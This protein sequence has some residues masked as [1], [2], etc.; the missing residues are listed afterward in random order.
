MG[1]LYPYDVYFVEHIYVS[2][3]N[4]PAELFPLPE[5]G[6]QSQRPEEATM[7]GFPS[8]AWEFS[9]FEIERD[10][11]DNNGKSWFSLLSKVFFCSCLFGPWTRRCCFEHDD[12][13]QLIQLILSRFIH[14]LHLFS[15]CFADI[16]PSKLWIIAY[17]N[18]PTHE[19]MIHPLNQHRPWNNLK[20]VHFVFQLPGNG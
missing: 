7:S 14:Q 4:D 8:A 6:M 9:F 1:L 16:F 5:P 2:N 13:T 3:P 15:Q 11:I 17:Q 18:W 19:W 20:I 12:R 10:W